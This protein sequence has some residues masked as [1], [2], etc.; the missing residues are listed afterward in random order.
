MLKKVILASAMA[1]SVAAC[2]NSSLLVERPNSSTYRSDS[3]NIVYDNSTVEVDEENLTYTQKE[4]E[5]AFFGG[6]EPLFTKG[7]G[8]TV[9]YR[10]LAFD[11]GS[12]TTRYF[13]GPFAGGSKVVM[14]VD[15]VDPN[16]TVMSTVRGEG[17]VSGGFFGGS[18]KSG[19][20]EAIE[21]VA[22][23][24]HTQFHN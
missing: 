22:E 18:N 3:A 4:M 20:Q 9:R 11:E 14:E 24:A 2:A 17:T 15:F 6:D 5:E 7:D 21:E 13:A 10:Y 23:Y 19:I 1:L 8:M 16:G 12:Q